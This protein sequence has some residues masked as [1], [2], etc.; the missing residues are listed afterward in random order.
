M[1]LNKFEFKIINQWVASQN[2]LD[3]AEHVFGGSIIIK[4]TPRAIER[5]NKNLLMGSNWFEIE[6]FSQF[7]AIKKSW[8]ESGFGETL[9]VGD[10]DLYDIPAS[11]QQY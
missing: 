11:G 8:S 4:F 5:L 9:G 3:E 10:L 2:V 1:I 7:K 6:D